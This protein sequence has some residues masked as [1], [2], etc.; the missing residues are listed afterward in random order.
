ML[1]ASWTLQACSK[2][3]RKSYQMVGARLRVRLVCARIEARPKTG[4]VLA[5]HSVQRA[6]RV[7]WTS[8]AWAATEPSVPRPN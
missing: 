3:A 4:K 5:L 7:K 2:T 8:G 1:T 6:G